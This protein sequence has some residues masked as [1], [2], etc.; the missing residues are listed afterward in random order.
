MIERARARRTVRRK[1]DPLKL[2]IVLLKVAVALLLVG[3]LLWS[4][5]WRDSLLRLREVAPLWTG[6]ALLFMGFGILVSAWKWQ[7]LLRARR[8]PVALTRLVR[9]YWI[10]V[11][12]SNLMPSNVGGDVVRVALARHLGGMAP[13]AASVLVER[14]TGFL[15][16]TVLALAALL[17]GPALAGAERLWAAAVGALLLGVLLLA[18]LLW[19]GDALVRLISAMP[20]PGGGLV[21]R[22]LRKLDALALTL[23]GYGADRRALLIACAVSVPFYASLVLVQYATIH[24]I[25]GELALVQVAAIAPLVALVSALPLSLN[26]IGIAEGAF[27]VLYVQAGLA[28]ETALAAAIL[29]RLIL[30]AVSLVGAPLWL[31][32]RRPAAGLDSPQARA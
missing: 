11:L 5:D 14:A 23:R 7:L 28:P 21:G 3:L 18:T 6:A 8:L 26:G 13:V 30:I 12:F 17:F 22:L 29:R 20:L 31:A 24:A 25:G 16:L 19:R 4:V 1:S 2:W 9:L 10:G 32:E 27:V 15:V